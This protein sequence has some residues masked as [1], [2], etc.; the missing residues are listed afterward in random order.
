MVTEYECTFYDENGGFWIILV[1]GRIHQLVFWTISNIFNIVL[2][3]TSI[4]EGSAYLKIWWVL[5]YEN[6][7]VLRELV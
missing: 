6:S 5:K 4:Q 1:G 2:L 7:K 3:L